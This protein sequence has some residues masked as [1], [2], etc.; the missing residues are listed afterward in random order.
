MG[1]TKHTGRYVVT[2]A[3]GQELLVTVSDE[4]AARF[5]GYKL[6]SLKVMRS[7]KPAG[8]TKVLA[9]YAQPVAVR[10]EEAERPSPQGQAAKGKGP[11]WALVWYE[12]GRP[13]VA[14]TL[15]EVAAH[16][17]TQVLFFPPGQLPLTPG[18]LGK[19][20]AAKDHE[21]RYWVRPETGRGRP[22]H[23]IVEEIEAPSADALAAWR[24]EAAA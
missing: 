5:L 6:A 3:E 22:L 7:A 2:S 11:R 18:K 12:D 1:R 15:A 9:G 10:F 8:W 14:G 21:V 24:E 23:A 13:G 4:E 19:Q 17:T 16:L 20:L